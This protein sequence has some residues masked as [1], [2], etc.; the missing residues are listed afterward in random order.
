MT[1]P[2]YFCT[3]CPF[4][5]ASQRCQW[6]AHRTHSGQ[7]RAGTHMKRISRVVGAG[8]LAGLVVA[9]GVVTAGADGTESLGVPSL[10]VAE[11]TGFVAAGV[12]T[13]VQPAA[14]NLAVPA[15]N[16]IK[17]VLVYWEGHHGS[18]AAG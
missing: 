12:G 13:E 2:S 4:R 18:V 15:G 7:Q 9:L 3:R 6:F 1:I 16:A 5:I 17:Q 14:I 8:L 10:T 11:G